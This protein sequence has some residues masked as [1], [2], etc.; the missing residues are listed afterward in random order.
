MAKKRTKTKAKEPIKIWV[1][2]LKNG[3]KAIYL[4]TYQAGS[5]GRGYT[6]ERLKGLLLVDDKRGS[7]KE[8]KAKNEATLR[9]AMLIR[10]ERIREWSMSHG[11]YQREMVTKDML[12][13]DWMLLYADQKRQQGQS[14]SHAVNIQHALLHLIRYKG[15]NIRMAQLDKVYCEGLVQYLAHA[16][17]IG[18]DVPKRG[19]HHEKDLAKG[20]ARLY[21]NTFVTALNEA[22][23]EGIIPE[24][25]TKLL[26]K[27]EKKLIGQ[28][29]SRRCYLSI[30]EIRLL[31]ATPCKD[32]TVKQAFL[33]ACFCGLRISDVRTLRWADI[34]KGT[35]GYYISKLMVKTRHVVTVPLSENAL[36]WMPARGQAR[37]D[38]KVFELPSF[39]SVNYRLKQWAR[40]AGIDKPVTFHVS[41]HN[42]TYYRLTIN[43]L[44]ITKN[45]TANDLETSYILFLSQLCNIQRTLWLRVQSY[46][47][48][49]KNNIFYS[50]FIKS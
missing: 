23:R 10:C 35:E 12:L 48:F 26:K 25:P 5:K 46:I 11:N 36:S 9:T 47:Y 38:D 2:P 15:E 8:A 34:G 40:E 20:T 39:F 37:A 33:F 4:C 3:N 7:D 43:E 42:K 21:Y 6:Y 28:G 44:S 13:K 45:V 18:T 17:T 31:M 41:S 19:E 30:E 24:N 22:V 29:E 50:D 1:K 49:L 16:K 32:E 14:G 27:E